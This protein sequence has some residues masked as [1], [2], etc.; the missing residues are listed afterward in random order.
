MIKVMIEVRGG[1]VVCVTSTEDCEIYIVDHDILAAG[2]DGD[3]MLTPYEPN[4][5]LDSTRE[6]EAH[7]EDA[8]VNSDD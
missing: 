5:L 4:L 3:K 7:L 2:D 6:F 1:S 8:I